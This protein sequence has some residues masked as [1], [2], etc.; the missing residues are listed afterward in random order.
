M[1][2]SLQDYMGMSYSS[3]RTKGKAPEHIDYQ[4]DNKAFAE[5]PE[6]SDIANNNNTTKVVISVRKRIEGMIQLTK[7][8]EVGW[9]K[10]R[11]VEKEGRERGKEQS[12]V[13]RKEGKKGRRKGAE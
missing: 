7:R 13:G 2:P 3:L 4:Y 1:V 11:E 6:Q 9:K 5:E 8:R 10:R 12:K